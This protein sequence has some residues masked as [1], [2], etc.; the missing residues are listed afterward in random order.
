MCGD[1]LD[2]A[3]L[4]THQ[5]HLAGRYPE[6]K[7]LDP[8]FRFVALAEGIA[9]LQKEN[10]RSAPDVSFW[11]SKYRATHIETAEE[12]PL[13]LQAAFLR[14]ADDAVRMTM[15]GGI[16]LKALVLEL[17]DGDAEAFKE[18]VLKSRPNG[19]PLVWN[20]PLGAWRASAA[21]GAA[22]EDALSH[23]PLSDR[24]GCT[25]ITRFEDAYTQDD[26]QQRLE[27][28]G[29]MLP[30]QIQQP[31]VLDLLQQQ[32]NTS[33]QNAFSPPVHRLDLLPSAPSVP[34]TFS[35]SSPSALM[36][37]SL[38]EPLTT[39][40]LRVPQAIAWMDQIRMPTPSLGAFA[41]EH[42][43]SSQIEPLAQPLQSPLNTAWNAVTGPTYD[44]LPTWHETLD[45]VTMFS[46]PLPLAPDFHA[47]SNP[48]LQQYAPPASPDNQTFNPTPSLISTIPS[49]QGTF[50]NYNEARTWNNTF[51]QSTPNAGMP[52]YN[53]S[54]PQIDLTPPGGY[55][56]PLMPS[57]SR[58]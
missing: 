6:L 12:Y 57:Q 54:S 46:A 51:Q 42:Q 40:T 15:E 17:G 5:K 2:H 39:I 37:E 48:S 8:L 34:P 18:V 55:N 14:K 20:V 9:S 53:H 3:H 45:N 56:P 49:I 29:M 31:H 47:F 58:P 11:L 28:I 25:I 21:N 16:E 7:R 19:N 32:G 43:L 4:V 26:M 1:Y 22:G 30:Q 13:L 44:P 35:P 10:S 50:Q 23:H 33:W 36:R 38:T 24:L 27:S 41:P 52:T